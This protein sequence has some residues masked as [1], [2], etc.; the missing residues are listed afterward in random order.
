V[1]T[2]EF[3]TYKINSTNSIKF[4]GIIVESSL[5]WKEH[6]DQVHSKLNPLGYIVRS[7]RP[8]LGLNILEQTYFSYVHSVL[9]NGIMFW[10][11]SSHSRSVFTTQKRIV[12]IITE[13]KGNDSFK[14]ML[15]YLSKM[16]C[17]LMFPH[18]VNAITTWLMDFFPT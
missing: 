11:N 8:V 6:V 14:E 10:S 13:A 5:T 16:K 12:R 4:L 15:Y 1:N 18:V 17:F 3:N 7:F 2:T 9:N